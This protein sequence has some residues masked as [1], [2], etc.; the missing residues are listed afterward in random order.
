VLDVL[1]A[2]LPLKQA[3]ALA[4]RISGAPRNAMYEL[5]LERR[6]TDESP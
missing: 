1:L 3:A 2:E 5:A 4:A 6:A